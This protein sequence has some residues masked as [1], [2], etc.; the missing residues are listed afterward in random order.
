MTVPIKITT[1]FF[2][3]I[4]NPMLKFMWKFKGT[5]ELTLPNFKT[6]YKATVFKTVCYWHENRHNK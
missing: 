4:D 3:E 6:S 1:D 5:R 2:A